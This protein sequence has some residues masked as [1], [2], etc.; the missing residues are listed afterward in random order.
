MRENLN[1]LIT[2][3]SRGIGNA[4][5]CAIA[6]RAENLIVTSQHSETLKK[7]IEKIRKGYD[8]VIHQYNV[9]QSLGETAAD[10][11]SKWVQGRVERIDA[12]ILCAGNFFEG[13]LES[14]SDDEFSNTM[15]TNFMFNY[16]IVRKLLPLL[17]LGKYPRVILIGSTAAYSS[18]S[19]PTYSISKFAL[20]GFA[21]NLRSE[22]MKDNV[23]VTFISPGGTLTD[24]WADVD[25]P[26][27]RLL[28]PEDIAITI[29]NLFNLSPQAVV[30]EIIIRPMLGEYN[31]E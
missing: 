1:I 23:G 4:I 22:L 24:M 25:V 27:N 29:D 31:D 10:E 9:D 3:A 8:G 15:N 30:E 7:G 11:L 6:H 5:A 12:L 20:R 17:K 18:Y 14:I 16:H 2:G 13:A 19:V 26:P 21:V 28:E